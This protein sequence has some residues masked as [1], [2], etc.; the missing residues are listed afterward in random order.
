[1]DMMQVPDYRTKHK[2]IFG[3]SPLD[4]VELLFNQLMY[5]FG[6]K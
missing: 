4:L 2:T 5:Q 3:R 1:M 6:K